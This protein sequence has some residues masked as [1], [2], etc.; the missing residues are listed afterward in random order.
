MSFNRFLV[1]RKGYMTPSPTARYL[2]AEKKGIPVEPEVDQW[3]PVLH[4]VWEEIGTEKFCSRLSPCEL[5]YLRVP[6]KYDL[7]TLDVMYN[8][9]GNYE[10]VQQKHAIWIP[11][12]EDHDQGLLVADALPPQAKKGRT[13]KDTTPTMRKIAINRAKGIS[14]Q[15]SDKALQLY[16]KVAKTDPATVAERINQQLP[17]DDPLLVAVIEKLGSEAGSRGTKIII[18]TI[19]NSI[20]GWIIENCEGREWIA[21]PYLKWLPSGCGV[22]V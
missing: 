2:C 1:A 16:S 4:E 19:P 20:K 21:E 10:F 15:L 14:F 12:N 9:V 3:D 11:E 13:D 6:A 5:E 22:A 8:T 17:R 7:D 18:L